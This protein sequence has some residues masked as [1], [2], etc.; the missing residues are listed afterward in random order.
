MNKGNIFQDL[1]M[2]K[3]KKFE[4]LHLFF[5]IIGLLVLEGIL[6]QFLPIRGMEEAIIIPFTL[7][8][9]IVNMYFAIEAIEKV[10]S[11][12][13]MLGLLFFIILEFITFFAFEYW[14]LIIFDPASFPTVTPDMLSL[15][16]HSTMVFVLNP[17]YLPATAA[18]KALILINTLSSLGIVIF[19]L[20]NI[21][22]LHHLGRTE[23]L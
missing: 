14:Y 21:W 16:F 4:I 22:Q 17:L 6:L 18:G 5:G 7:I 2:Y 15:L 9:T 3:V 12:L 11:R 8:G 13:A 20:Q 23:Q 19:I 1:T 10:N